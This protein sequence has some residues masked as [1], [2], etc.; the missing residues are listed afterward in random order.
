MASLGFGVRGHDDPGAE[1][2]EWRA[3]WGG[4]SAP[5]PTIA[6]RAPPAEPRPLAHFLHIL[7]HRT[8]LVSRKI[9]FSC[10]EYKEKVVFLYENMQ[11]L[12]I[13]L[14]TSGGDSHHHFQ[15]WWWQVTIV[16]YK[17]APM[18]RPDPNQS[19][20]SGSSTETYPIAF[21]AEAPTTADRITHGRT[22]R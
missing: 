8:L 9:R 18:T 19:Y 13:P 20:W 22:F 5:Q 2:A 1:G 16:T 11:K 15:K 3:V 7:G 10:P 4:V 12:Q 21:L 17:V 14:W 6:L